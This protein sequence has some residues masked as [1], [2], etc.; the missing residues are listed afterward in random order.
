VTVVARDADGSAQGAVVGTTQPAGFLG[1]L[2]KNRWPGGFLLASARAL[3]SDPK[4]APRLLRAVRYCGD[5]PAS[6]QGALL[7]S[8]CVD[9]LL[10]GTGVG[11]QLVEAWTRNVASRAGSSTFLTTDAHDND[12]VNRFHQTGLGTL[13]RPHHA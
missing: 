9:P 1:R 11:R 13:R 2:L 3:V 4:A 12:G 7:S 6:V 10:Q 8:I 5:V